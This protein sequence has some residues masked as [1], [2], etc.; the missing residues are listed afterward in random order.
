MRMQPGQ[1]L[2]NYLMEQELKHQEEVRRRLEKQVRWGGR[3]SPTDFETQP[4]RQVQ[5]YARR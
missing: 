3:T 1:D 2:S 5:K 4:S